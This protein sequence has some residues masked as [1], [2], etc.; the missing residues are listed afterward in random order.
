MSDPH[1]NNETAASPSQPDRRGFLVAT[2]ATAA[3]A[4]GA[5]Y[6]VHR[7][8]R[9]SSVFIARHQ[10]YTGELVRTIRDGLLAC[11]F[12]PGTIRGKRVLLKPNLVEPSRLSPQMTTHPIVIQ[13]AVEVFRGWDADVTVGEGPGHVRDTEQALMESGVMEA[14][15]EV[16]MSFEDLNYQEIRPVANAGKACDLKQFYFPRAVIEADLV[17]SMPKMKTHHWMGMTGAMKNLYGVIPGIKYG[18]PKNVLHFNGIPQTV[19]DINASVG[20][21]IAIV[22]GIDCME[23][24]GPIL[25]TPKNMGLILVGTNLTAV[26][27]TMARLMDILPDRIPYLALAANRLGPI[28]ENRIVQRGEQWQPLVDPFLIL[29]RKHLRK[30]RATNSHFVT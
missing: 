3:T 13:A 17:V 28:D 10:S 22:D 16:R 19:Y 2:A 6:L 18:W 5:G 25:G 12:D 9:K 8:Q 24:D 20:R 23:G 29:D 15:Q 4:A 1:P 26:D 14:L 30:L 27:A 11:E 21:R 7:S